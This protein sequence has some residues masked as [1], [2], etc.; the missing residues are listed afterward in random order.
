MVKIMRN[1]QMVVKKLCA[2]QTN[3]EAGIVIFCSIININTKL[4]INIIW[5][6]HI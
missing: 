4:K 1:T 3:A 5:L 6:P 2:D